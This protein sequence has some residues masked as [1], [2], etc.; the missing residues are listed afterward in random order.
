MEEDTALCLL[1]Q[2]LS[3][4]SRQGRLDYP[5]CSLFLARGPRGY[6]LGQWG[7]FSFCQPRS[8]IF[9]PAKLTR[10]SSEH[11]R[12][13]YMDLSPNSDISLLSRYADRAKQIRCN[14]IINEDPNNKLI[15]E[16]KDEVT[17]LRDLLYAQGLGDI[18]DSECLC[19]PALGRAGASDLGSSWASCPLS[20]GRLLLMC[21]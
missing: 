6:P 2:N 15:R 5:T 19:Q 4:L 1:P 17:R 14:A 9:P 7:D 13:C 16:L 20:W 11:P 3:F 18:T 8:K 21:C 10:Q 12:A